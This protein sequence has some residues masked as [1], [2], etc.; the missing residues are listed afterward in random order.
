MT[1]PFAAMSLTTV[2]SVSASFTTTVT[3]SLSPMAGCAVESYHIVS[4]GGR[5]AMVV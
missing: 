1:A 3:V 5:V 2:P 4:P